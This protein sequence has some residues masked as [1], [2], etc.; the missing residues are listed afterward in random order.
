MLFLGTFF[1]TFIANIFPDAA[2]ATFRT[3]K[4]YKKKKGMTSSRQWARPNNDKC[5]ME[6]KNVIKVILWKDIWIRGG[7]LSI[8]ALSQHSQQL[9]TLWPDVLCSLID[10]VLRYLDLLTVVH[11]AGERSNVTICS[12]TI[13]WPKHGTITV[14]TQHNYF[15]YQ[16]FIML[17]VNTYNSKPLHWSM[18][19]LIWAYDRKCKLEHCKNKSA[20]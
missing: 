6:L 5:D 8:T 17:R 20:L 16:A 15:I 12:L 3:W 11:I 18:K 4:T 13:H 7:Y 2:P 10:V 19:S 9:K 1:K 14:T